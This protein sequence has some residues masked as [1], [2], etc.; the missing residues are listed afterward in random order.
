MTQPPANVVPV[1]Y[2][3]PDKE[4]YVRCNRCDRPIC[5]NCMNEASVGFQCP[6]CVRDGARS[7]H[8]ARTT[9]GGGSSGTQGTVTITLIV[10][11]VMAFLATI[12][13]AGTG[14]VAGGGWGGLLSGITPLHQHFGELGYASYAPGGAPHGIAAG[15]YYRLLTAMFLHFG[16]LHLALNMWG[17]WVVG[18]PLEAAL[19]RGRFLALYLIAGLGGGVAA[20]LFSAPNTITAGASGALF[21]L[22]GALVVVLRRLRLSI[23]GVLPVLVLNLVITFSFSQISVGGHIGGLITGALAAIGLAYAP[24]KHRTLVQTLTIAVLALVLVVAAVWR[25]ASLVG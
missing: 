25:T 4:T 10:L 21:G 17:V 16:V 18:R 20:Y 24:Q 6:E 9:F 19:G 13:S 14:A 3:H 11:N 2:R 8:P 12:V 1:C 15:E 22:F 7:Q 23:A 5:P